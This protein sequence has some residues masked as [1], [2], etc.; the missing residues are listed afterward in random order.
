MSVNASYRTSVRAGAGLALVAVALVAML[1]AAGPA[2]DAESAETAAGVVQVLA[3]AGAGCTAG[4]AL[5]VICERRR[6]RRW[7]QSTR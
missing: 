1:L 5:G 2:L 4:A 7:M 3:G 6:Q